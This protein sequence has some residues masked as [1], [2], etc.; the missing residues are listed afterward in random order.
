M[1]GASW[2]G[3]W[4]ATRLTR[5]LIRIKSHAYRRN[6]LRACVQEGVGAFSQDGVRRLSYGCT[7]LPLYR[8]L[9]KR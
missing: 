6:R 5:R 7:P 1:L 4:K 9:L 8:S 2:S 3:V